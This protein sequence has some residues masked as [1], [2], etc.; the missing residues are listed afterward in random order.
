MSANV[1]GEGAN[2]GNLASEVRALR[3][4]MHHSLSD[5]LQEVRALRITEENQEQLLETLEEAKQDQRG[6]MGCLF[7]HSY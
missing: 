6:N 5:V 7:T 1:A 3:R 2:E 4:M